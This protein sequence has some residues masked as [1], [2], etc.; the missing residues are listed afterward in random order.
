M[1]HATVRGIPALLAVMLLA[2]CANEEGPRP[3]PEESPVE[4]SGLFVDRIETSGIDFVHRTGG[5]GRKYILEITTGGVCVF[6]QDGDGRL[7][8]YFPQ[9]RPLPGTEVGEEDYSDRLY[10]GVGPWT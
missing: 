5:S 1:D 4:D 8:L 2:A 10:R 7:D 6:D 9:G 3:P